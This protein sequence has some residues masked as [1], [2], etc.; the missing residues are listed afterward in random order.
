MAPCDWVVQ[1][2]DRDE[3][4]PPPPP[5]ESHHRCHPE[6]TLSH[7]DPDTGAEVEVAVVGGDQSLFTDNALDIED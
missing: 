7:I 6:E 1:Q 2:S 3:V 4:G 5:V